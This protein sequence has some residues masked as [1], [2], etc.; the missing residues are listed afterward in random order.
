MIN[1]TI[2]F[3]EELRPH[4]PNIF[5]SNLNQGVTTVSALVLSIV[6]TRLGSKELYGQ[7][8][9][10]LAMFGLF[11][12]ISIPGVRTVI[13]RTTAQGYD[14]V[15]RKATKFSFL[16]SLLGIPL[17]VAAGVFFY[18]FKTKILGITLIVFALFFPFVESLQN[19]MLYLKGGSEFR[20]L[21]FYNLVKILISLIAVTLS[22][23]FTRNIIV[24]LLAYFLV[25]SG[26]NILYHFQSVKSL[27]ND[28]LDKGW[29][30]Q[31][32]ALTIMGLSS[33]IFGRVDIVLIGALLPLGQV[34]VYGLVMKFA[35]AFF[36]I[37]RGTIEAVLPNL[38]QS[39]K[40]TIRYFYGYFLLSFLV[41]LILYP[42]VKYPILLMYPKEFSQVIF[43][44]QVY[45]AII[46]FYFFNSIASCFMVKYQLNAEI[47]ISRIASMTILIA[48]YAI[49]IPLY[50]VW[51]GVVSSMLYFIIQLLLNLSLLKIRS[52]KRY[53]GGQLQ[54]TV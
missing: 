48:L 8:L 16:L 17:L 24:I 34:A 39:K 15:Y 29:K 3:I 46:P 50:G 18:L 32:Y 47:N 45:L 11:S 25:S 53:Q 52:T 6:F 44:S 14:G 37:I 36:Q 1:K 22:I 27:R 49:L 54:G 9:F 33:I 7:Y 5:W 4:T 43:L 38:F 41:P 40:I 51:G 12:I 19:W 2:R 28:K 21:T 31:S 20:K 10:V 26:F 13:F 30:K 42:I 23:V 35:D